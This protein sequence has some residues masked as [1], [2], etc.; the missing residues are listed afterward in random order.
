[1]TKVHLYNVVPVLPEPL[2]RLT[3]LADNL[4]WSWDPELFGLFR[5][6][7][8]ALWE[9]TS[10]NPARLL[11]LVDQARLDELSEDEGFLHHLGQMV[12]RH[13]RYLT[14]TTD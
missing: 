2:Q 13:Q 3:E 1:M 10:N 8:P 5:R 9:E 6:I 4:L 11:G 12:D 14:Q 7:D